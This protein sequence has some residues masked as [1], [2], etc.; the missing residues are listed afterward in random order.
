MRTLWR[1]ALAGAALLLAAAAVNAQVY[2]DDPYWRGDRDRD[3]RRDYGYNAQPYSEIERVQGDLNRAMGFGYLSHGDRRTLEK[4]QDDLYDLQ[5]Q[6]SRGHYSNHELDE[7]I[8]RI[9][10]VVNHG[11]LS[12]RE[13]DLLQDDANRLRDLRA[14]G[15]YRY[16]PYGY[17]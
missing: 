10:N 3:Y 1:N 9:Q 14:R 7:A 4:A 12:Y 5:R 11:R 13:R 16:E 2:R 8:G 6:W 17:R 15:G